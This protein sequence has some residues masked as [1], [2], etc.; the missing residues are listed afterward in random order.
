MT[1]ERRRSSFLAAA[2]VDSETPETDP[3]ATEDQPLLQPPK[4]EDWTPPRGF[5]WIEAG[6]HRLN[7]QV[8]RVANG[9]SNF[10]RRLPRGLRW[11]HHRLNI[12]RHQLRVQCGQHGIM[13]HHIVPHYQHSLPAAV[14]ALLRHLWQAHLLLYLGSHLHAG[15][16]GLFSCPRCHYSQLDASI[17]GCRWWRF[18]DYG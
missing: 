10:R 7:D 8:R 4:D 11:N 3:Q 12:R 6:R 16:L 9:S 5:L 13:A 15:L 18:D 2:E 17:D 14:W 1:A